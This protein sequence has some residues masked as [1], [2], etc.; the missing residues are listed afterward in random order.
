MN[1]NRKIKIGILTIALG[2]SGI[3]TFAQ[4]VAAVDT[5]G[6]EET[7]SEK[8]I[9]QVPLELCEQVSLVVMFRKMALKCS[10]SM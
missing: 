4:D 7:V 9:T 8:H 1:T 2:S 6:A 10:T 3:P 5:I